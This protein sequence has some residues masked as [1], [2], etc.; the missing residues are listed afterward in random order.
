MS[1]LIPF[2]EKQI[3]HK[4]KNENPWWENGEIDPHYSRM[5]KRLYLELFLPLVYESEIKRA[6]VLM[7]PR[8][9]GKT[10]LLYH[11]IQ[12]IID[13]GVNPLKI[14][15]LSVENPIF[16]GL[17]LEQLLLFYLKESNL[18][19]DERLYV[20]FDEIQYLK[21]WE[22]HLKTLVD[23]YHEIKFIVSGSAAA[24]LRLK[25][26]ES[27][28][29]RFTDFLLPPLT[30]HEYI[31]L[32]DLSDLVILNEKEWNGV[33]KNYYHTNQIETFNQHF[34]D[35]INFGGYPE[36]SLSKEIQSDPG[37]YIRHDII[38]KVLLR[39]LPSL[40]GIQDVQ[41]LNSLFTTIAYNSGNEF[42]YEELSTGS[43]VAKNTIK[44]YIEYLEAAFLIKVIHKIDITPKKFKRATLFKIYLTNPSLRSAL[45]SPIDSN[46]EFIGN[47][48][49]TAIY[50]QWSHNSDFTPYY[51]RWS[52]GEVDIV[53]LTPNRQKPQW[54]VEIKWSNRPT[55]SLKSLINITNF[56]NKN[57]LDK[58]LITTIDIS[59]TK[60]DDGIVYDFTPSSLYCYT[61]GKN[62]IDKKIKTTNLAINH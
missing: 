34:L 1:Y 44:R 38:D 62:V 32:K 17:S 20:I 46:D 12:N 24:A 48:V 13:K 8:R 11:T 26:N 42:S 55:K 9:V 22:L 61:V 54:A 33:R 14:C 39:D 49:E 19:S 5:R 21:N 45:F 53:S 59:E 58:A 7:G 35:Y 4:I 36:V 28:A 57:G 31:D 25:S 18:N 60:E 37:R 2:S 47:M 23:T 41:E 50:S 51:A 27:G 56:C 40:Y 30:F 43:G 52:K 15:F 29:G 6:I 16:N 10:V 3:L